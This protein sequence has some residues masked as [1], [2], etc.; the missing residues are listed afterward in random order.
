MSNFQTNHDKPIFLRLNFQASKAK[1]MLYDANAYDVFIQ[2][3]KKLQKSAP[4]NINTIRT[5]SIPCSSK[6]RRRE[7]QV[8]HSGACTHDLAWVASL[9]AWN[10]A[11]KWKKQIEKEE[12]D[13]GCLGPWA[14][15]PIWFDH[16]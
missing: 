14:S 4:T 13:P 12:S 8:V 5:P 7:G 10:Y 2:H 1:T 11:K 9:V 3:Q 16:V 15:G 6:P